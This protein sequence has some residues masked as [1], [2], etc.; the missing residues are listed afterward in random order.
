MLEGDENV[1]TG[2]VSVLRGV[3]RVAS[4]PEKDCH[5]TISRA[6][7]G[8]RELINIFFSM[9]KATRSSCKNGKTSRR[10]SK[11]AKDHKMGVGTV[12]I[13]RASTTDKNKDKDECK[14]WLHHN[15]AKQ[16]VE[17]ILK[18]ACDRFGH[19]WSI[20]T[21]KGALW[22]LEREQPN[23]SDFGGRKRSEEAEHKPGLVL[24]FQI[25]AMLDVNECSLDVSTTAESAEKKYVA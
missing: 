24:M 12:G 15:E 25:F 21:K 1:L 17:K 5:V 14:I 19:I 10:L 23:S 22:R 13:C 7:R 20:A 11:F 8:I 4:Q 18:K 16:L 6:L 3:S 9:S 2:F